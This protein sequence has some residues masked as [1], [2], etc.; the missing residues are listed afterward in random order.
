M[1][2]ELRNSTVV[3]TGATGGIGRAIAA[4]LDA[5]GA[6]LLL[7]ARTRERLQELADSLTPREHVAIAADLG[8]DSGR[9]KVRDACRGAGTQGISLLINCAG[10]THFGLYEDQT[11]EAVRKVIDVNLTGPMLLCLDLMP[12]LQ[13]ANQACIIN[14]GSTFGSIGYPG[15]SA[16]CASKFGLRGFTEALRR[17]LGDA[18]PRVSYVAPRATRTELNSDSIVAMNDALGTAMDEPSLVA[19][20]VMQV[21]HG[22]AASTR[23]IGWP[24]KLFI[25]I[26]ALFPGLVDNSLRKQLPVIRRF[27]TSKP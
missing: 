24:E 23:Y 27:A 21:I 4:R 12:F 13:R 14:I 19:E 26:N 9:E 18:G 5:A 22:P 7:V 2:M 8:E 3:L 16:Y 25:R 6:R 17:E 20:E 15:F 1:S 10:I 11:S